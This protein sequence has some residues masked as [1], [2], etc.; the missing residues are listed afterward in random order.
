M[1]YDIVVFVYY[2]EP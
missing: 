1:I 2:K